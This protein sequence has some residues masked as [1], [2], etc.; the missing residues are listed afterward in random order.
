MKKINRTAVVLAPKNVSNI[1][2][3]YSNRR[4]EKSSQSAISPHVPVSLRSPLLYL[5][6]FMIHLEIVTQNQF[7]Y[8]HNFVALLLQALQDRVQHLRRVLRVV[9]EKD[10]RAVPQMLV[11][12]D[13]IDL[14]ICTLF[15]PVETVTI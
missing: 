9:V 5:P 8:R 12:Q 3:E 14:R 15:L 6:P 4:I 2:A 1:S 13:L 10:D 11:V 7:G